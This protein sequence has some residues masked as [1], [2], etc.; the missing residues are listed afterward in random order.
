MNHAIFDNLGEV[1]A[2]LIKLCQTEGARRVPRDKP[3]RELRPVLLECHKPWHPCIKSAGVNYRFAMAEVMA[4]IN[5]WNDVAWL[6]QFNSRISAFSDDGLIFNGA[7]GHRLRYPIDQLKE[8]ISLLNLDA[9][10]RQV[11]FNIW[12]PVQ[13]YRRTADKACN[14]Q[15]FVKLIPRQDV[16][17]SGNDPHYAL[18]LTVF[19]RS[20]DLIWGVPYDHFVFCNLLLILARFV[21]AVPGVLREYIDSLHVYEPEAEFYSIDRVDKSLQAQPSTRSLAWT[22]LTTGNLVDGPLQL[23]HLRQAFEITRRA[24][25]DYR[26]PS[27]RLP[28]ELYNYLREDTKWPAL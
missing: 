28:F 14:T 22:Q 27:H 2:D 19:R 9:D 17:L 16:E 10:C 18:D 21:H 3:N 11:V 12:D 23:W 26:P 7:Y 13:D 5:G 6:A 15:V 8:G 24:L 25:V 4:L 20:S 1:Y